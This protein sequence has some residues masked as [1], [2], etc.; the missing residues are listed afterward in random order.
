MLSTAEEVITF[1]IRSDLYFL[2]FFR[3]GLVSFSDFFGIC[4]S[5]ILPD[6]HAC[7][8]RPPG[9]A[10]PAFHFFVILQFACPDNRGLGKPNPKS[11][12]KS[13]KNNLL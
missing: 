5:T 13:K 7:E 4:N 3:Y 6:Y 2:G 9:R 1:V 8:N 12:P 10:K 11:S